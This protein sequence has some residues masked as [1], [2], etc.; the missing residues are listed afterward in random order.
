MKKIK[1]KSIITL[2]Y[3]K[4]PVKMKLTEIESFFKVTSDYIW[5]RSIRDLSSYN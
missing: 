3:V 4:T 1:K 5:N 2:E